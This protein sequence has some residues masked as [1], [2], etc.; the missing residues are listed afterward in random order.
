M[1]PPMLR[2]QPLLIIMFMILLPLPGSAQTA[3]ELRQKYK[4]SSRVESYDVR[5]GIIA[6]VSYGEDG[7]VASILLTPPVAYDEIGV[8]QNEMPMTVVEEVLNEL[9]P[10]ARR[11]EVCEN[12]GLGGSASALRRRVDY[13]N[14]RIS[15]VTRGDVAAQHLLV[16]WIKCAGKIRP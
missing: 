11:G 16:E 10:V 13:E 1:R 14:V 6:V 8:T 9:V 4:V 3:A 5:P 7:R 12:Y 2:Y 15:S